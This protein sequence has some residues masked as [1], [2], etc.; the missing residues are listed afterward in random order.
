MLGRARYSPYRRHLVRSAKCAP[1]AV[2]TRLGFPATSD[3]SQPPII[4]RPLRD[5]D[6][7]NCKTV[8]IVYLFVLSGDGRMRPASSN[9]LV[10]GRVLA[11]RRA[12]LSRRDC[13]VTKSFPNWSS[14]LQ[15]SRLIVSIVLIVLIQL[16]HSMAMCL[17]LRFSMYYGDT[18]QRDLV[19]LTTFPRAV[20]TF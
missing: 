14:H 11:P 13:G 10:S 1:S 3:E 15:D 16:H 20:K 19:H 2:F 9:E 8:K 18:K 4:A 17:K 6:V 5:C 12:L 7:S